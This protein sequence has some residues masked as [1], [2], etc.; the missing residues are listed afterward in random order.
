MIWTIIFAQHPYKSGLHDV[1]DRT[2]GKRLVEICVWNVIVLAGTGRCQ[3]DER[4]ENAHYTSHGIVSIATIAT[5]VIRPSIHLKRKLQKSVVRK[6][7]ASKKVLRTTENNLIDL[8]PSWQW[9]GT[10]IEDEL[11][12]MEAPLRQPT[13]TCQASYI[14]ETSLGWLSWV[15]QWFASRFQRKRR[16]SSDS[17]FHQISC[18]PTPPPVYI[19]HSVAMQS[20]GRWAQWCERLGNPINLQ[21]AQCKPKGSGWR[22]PKRS[23]QCWLLRPK[24]RRFPKLFAPTNV[25]SR[26]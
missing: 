25:E 26:T 1:T 10:S 17:T 22:S 6:K 15:T 13:K 23:R 2:K 12:T 21:Y 24:R 3:P 5:T 19:Y 8:I 20:F 7:A 9:T 18:I 14:L 11:Q 4:F 16:I